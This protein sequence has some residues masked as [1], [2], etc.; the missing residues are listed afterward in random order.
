MSKSTKV[1]VVAH[2]ETGAVITPRKNNP[3]YG[4][5]RLDQESVSMENG[6]LNKSNRTAWLGGK[7]EDLQSL[8]LKA[9]STLPGKI[10]RKE[11]HTPFYE[12]QSPKINPQTSEVVL[13][14]GKEVYMQDMYTD[15]LDASSYSF[16]GEEVEALV[17]AEVAEGQAI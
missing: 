5:I 9:G 17:E 13:K 10:V 6:Y 2:P 14:D 8:N 15:D 7:I 3:E 12:G 1:T 11:S 16:I 4:V